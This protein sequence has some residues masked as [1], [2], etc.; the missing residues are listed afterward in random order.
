M[1]SINLFLS[2]DSIRVSQV[3]DIELGSLLVAHPVCTVPEYLNLKE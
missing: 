3:N 1:S 2:A